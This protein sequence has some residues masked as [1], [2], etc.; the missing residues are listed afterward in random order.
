MPPRQ[1]FEQAV[2]RAGEVRR[3][4]AGRASSSAL[5]E[6]NFISVPAKGGARFALKFF[7]GATKFAQ[8]L[9]C[10]SA[11]FAGAPTPARWSRPSWKFHI[12]SKLLVRNLFAALEVVR[13]E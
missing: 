10:D 13:F 5:S 4:R 11:K 2:A 3:L 7:L 1:A 9:Q 12:L 6:R 8:P